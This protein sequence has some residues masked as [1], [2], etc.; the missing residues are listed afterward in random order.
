MA[1]FS[2]AKMTWQLIL[3]R[4]F[5]WELI[6]LPCTNEV[7][8]CHQQLTSYGHNPPRIVP[9]QDRNIYSRNHTKDSHQ[10]KECGTK[11]LVFIRRKNR[12]EQGDGVE[13]AHERDHGEIDELT[14]RV[15]LED[16]VDGREEGRDDHDGDV[17][18]VYTKKLHAEVEG[19]TVEEMADTTREEAEHGVT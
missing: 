10:D 11:T 14:Y 17:E 9:E 19:V 16:V 5:L 13:E 12:G 4:G 3:R 8:E 18:V 15:A 6:K 2:L 7:K 1:T